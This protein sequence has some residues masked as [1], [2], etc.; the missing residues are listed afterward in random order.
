MAS[1]NEPI[2]ILEESNSHQAASE[3]HSIGKEKASNTSGPELESNPAINEVAWENPSITTNDVV[4]ASSQIGLLSLPPELRLLV[5][6]Q[7]LLE[8]LEEGR[9]LSTEWR[10]ERYQLFTAI[11]HTCTLIRQEA[12]QVMYGENFF[13]I[14]FSHPTH[15]ILDNQKVRDTIQNVHFVAGRPDDTLIRKN[16]RD[17]IHIIRQFRSPAIVRGTFSILF[18][19]GGHRRD[20]FSWFPRYLPAFTNFRVIRITFV[21]S[22][23]NRHD[24]FHLTNQYYVE[25]YST[26][27]D[28]YERDF[29]PIFGPA[30]SYADGCGLQFHPQDYLKSLPPKVDDDWMD[31]LDGIRLNWNQDPTNPDE[32]G[33][34][35]QNSNPHSQG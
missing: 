26:F 15:S 25:T 13:F 2:A 11:L 23:A 4:P 21:F 35:V 22:F 14:G 7:L 19:V 1:E 12:F 9:A 8:P 30:L 24:P 17:L 32:H 16:E 5:Y 29:T 10:H 27:C 18:Y 3:N 28:A 33:A 20:H 31:Y 6:R 34:S